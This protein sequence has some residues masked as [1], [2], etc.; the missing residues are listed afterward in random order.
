MGREIISKF[1]HDS[2]K[3]IIGETFDELRS[4]MKKENIDE[5]FKKSCFAHFLE[6]SGPRPL[7]FPMIIVY[8]LLKHRITYAGDDGGL[9][10][11]RN[12]MDEVSINY[13]GMPICFG[14][15]EF[16]IVT[17]L[18]CDRPEEPAIKKTPHKSYK[19]KDF[20]ADLKNKDIPK[21]YREKLCL[22][23]FVHSVLLARDVK[24]VI[25]RDLLVLADDFGRFN[26]YSWGYNNYYLTVKYLLK[27]LKP[28][29]T[30]LYGF[31]WAFMVWASEAIPPLRK[32]FMDYLDM[33]SHPRILRW[34]AAVE[35][36]KKILTRLISLT[37]RIMQCLVDTKED[38]TVDL[39]K[40][41]LDG[42]TSIR[43]AVR[44]SQSNVED[45]HDLTQTATDPGASSG[46]VA[47]GVVC[48]GGSH[49]ASA[50]ASAASHD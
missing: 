8:G 41:E 9:K 38:P 19:V 18:R 42:E 49:P 47:G 33:V 35:S 21:N 25:E 15:K 46:G 31:P 4:I 6:L 16:V 7:R 5:L 45:L 3:T 48:D 11:G 17:G 50:F 34:L 32:Y 22:V 43:R 40:K 30:T 24:K 2:F 14:L 12:K 37:L 23:W 39:I 29:T 36:S 1:Q 26:D 10:K 13:C 44:Q 28:K 27:E 20:I